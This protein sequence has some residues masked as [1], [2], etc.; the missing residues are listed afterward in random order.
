M[1][2]L[3]GGIP[4]EEDGAA[5]QGP[6]GLRDVGVYLTDDEGFDRGLVVLALGKAYWLLRQPDGFHLQVD[7][8]DA[9][10][11]REQIEAFERES[12]GWPPAEPQIPRRPVSL[13]GP[14]LWAAALILGYY[15]E[16]RSAG[17]L[18]A[19]GTMDSRALFSQGQLWRPFTALLLHADAGHLAANLLTGAV[20]V[21]ALLTTLG[22]VRGWLLLAIASAAGNAAVGALSY[23]ADYR[24]LGAST[25]VFAALGLLTG[26]ALRAS[27][28]ASFRWAEL[29]LPLG[30]GITLLGMFG[31]GDASTDV[32]AHLAGFAAGLLLGLAFGRRSA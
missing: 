16:G 1:E 5:T 4:P 11:V 14:L 21:S 12:A 24:S 23:P 17:R 7:A 3:N 10:Q 6:E 31:S 22:N 30:S 25:A 15:L 2:I 19:W 18:E 28:G 32:A 9:Q 20:V 13:F 26:T 27:R 29:L 8:A